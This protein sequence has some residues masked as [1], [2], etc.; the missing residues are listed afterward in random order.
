MQLPWCRIDC[1]DA[2]RLDIAVAYIKMGL[3]DN[4]RRE[5]QASIPSKMTS[6]AILST[7]RNDYSMELVLRQAIDRKWQLLCAFVVYEHAI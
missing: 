3:A 1:S 4:L 2:K 6:T 7:K 5:R